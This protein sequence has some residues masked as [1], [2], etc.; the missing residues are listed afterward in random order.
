MGGH[1]DRRREGR[2]WGNGESAGPDVTQGTPSA[3]ARGPPA[4]IGSARFHRNMGL[5]VAFSPLLRTSESS[6]SRTWAGGRPDGIWVATLWAGL[7]G[8]I[9]PV[10]GAWSLLTHEGRGGPIGRVLPLLPGSFGMA[11]LICSLG[12]WRGRGRS[13]DALAILTVLQGFLLAWIVHQRE[14]AGPRKGGSSPGRR[15]A[16]P[17]AFGVGMAGYRLT[18]ERAREFFRRGPQARAEE[19][20]PHPEVG[21]AGP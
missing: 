5:A 13:R 18:R 6:P 10:V 21:D 19:E 15:A 14:S 11:V 20:P 12:A 4:S 9:V 3:T 1:R 8:G 17:I 2:R 16:G 7:S